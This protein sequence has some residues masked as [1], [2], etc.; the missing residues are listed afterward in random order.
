MIASGRQN[1]ATASIEA[2][3]RDRW[4]VLIAAF[5]GWMFDG[6]EQ[7]IFPL[8]ARPALQDLMGAEA[9]TLIGPWM[10]YITALFLLGAACGGFLFGWIG[11]RAGRVRAMIYSIL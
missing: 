4:L 3:Q 8:V 7:G 6:L 1:P 11:D 2:S 5:L 9:D 10:G